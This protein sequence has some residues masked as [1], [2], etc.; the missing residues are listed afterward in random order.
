MRFICIFGWFLTYLFGFVV[1]YS[2]FYDIDCFIDFLFVSRF[3]I[4]RHVCKVVAIDV[5]LFK[6]LH[7]LLFSQESPFNVFC[8]MNFLSQETTLPLLFIASGWKPSNLIRGDRACSFPKMLKLMEVS[9]TSCLKVPFSCK[10]V[11]SIT[12][13]ILFFRN[14]FSQNYMPQDGSD[15]IISFLLSFFKV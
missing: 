7:C 2:W 15:Y 11:G 6:I 8:W 1:T 12:F 13:F 14:Y 3:I 10:M 4:L 5:V 9:V